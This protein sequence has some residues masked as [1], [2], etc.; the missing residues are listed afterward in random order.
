[1]ANFKIV[2]SDPKSR[3]AYQKEV[4]QNA[5]ALLGKKIGDPVKGDPM[6]L[7]GYELQVTGG[8]DNDGFPM[9]T[10][11]EGTL[12][13]KLILSGGTGFHPKKKG[14]RKRKSVRGN[15][16]SADISQVNLKVIKAGSKPLEQ[17]IGK[18]EKPKEGEEAKAE[19]KKEEAKPEEKPEEK[20]EEAKPEE[21][22][23]SKEEA[24]KEEKPAEKPEEK[25]EETKAEEKAKEGKTQAKPESNVTSEKPSEEKKE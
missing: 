12:R 23:P 4:D 6:G 21:K 1:M 19:E 25:K 24:P 10:D 18:P 9:R 20:K 7:A 2:V 11:V 22:A 15:T 8:S 3:K 17:L 16:I 13:K 5:S 14:L